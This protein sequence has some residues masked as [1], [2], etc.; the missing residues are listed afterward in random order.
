MGWRSGRFGRSMTPSTRVELLVVLAA[1][2]P[3]LLARCNEQPQGR[4]EQ[5]LAEGGCGKQKQRES[6]RERAERR[7]VG[8]AD[9]RGLRRAICSAAATR[10]INSSLGDPWLV[11]CRI[12]WSSK[13]AKD[14][15]FCLLLPNPKSQD[16]LQNQSSSCAL[17]SGTPGSAS[18]RSVMPLTSDLQTEPLHGAH[19]MLD[20]RFS[21]LKIHHHA[22]EHAIRPGSEV[23]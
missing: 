13:Q 19:E 23:D 18:Q 6:W 8:E 3:H 9:S 12:Q 20:S 21:C 7:R 4:A 22:Q 5:G 10:S 15:C 1:L 17:C 2:C 14:A 11:Q 16:L